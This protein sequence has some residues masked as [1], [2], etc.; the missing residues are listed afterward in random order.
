MLGGDDRRAFQRL[1]R[2]RRKVA[3]VAE[4]GGDDVERAGHVT[5]TP[6]TAGARRSRPPAGRSG[7]P[8]WRP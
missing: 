2:A 4:R 3:E 7:A 1:G 5:T 6:A 8:A